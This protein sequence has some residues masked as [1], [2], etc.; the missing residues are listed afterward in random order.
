MQDLYEKNSYGIFLIR[1]LRVHCPTQ[2]RIQKIVGAAFGSPQTKYHYCFLIVERRG[3][4][5]LLLSTF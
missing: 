2:I 3:R 5:S 1:N 4:R